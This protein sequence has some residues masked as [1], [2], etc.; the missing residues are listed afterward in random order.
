MVFLSDFCDLF[1]EN[2]LGQHF[3]LIFSN[4]VCLT[5]TIRPSHEKT[6]NLGFRPGPTQT[7]LYKHRRWLEAGNV[8]F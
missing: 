8:G 3:F 2:S 4:L 6:N 5:I 1:M 7:E